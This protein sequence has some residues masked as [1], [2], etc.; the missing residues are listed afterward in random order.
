MMVSD[1]FGPA[2]ETFGRTMYAVLTNSSIAAT[3]LDKLLV[4]QSRTRSTSS[5]V[6]DS[7]A[8]AT[9]FSCAQK[10]YNGAIAVTADEKPCATVLEAA[11]ALGYKTGLVVTSRITHATPASF[12]AHVLWRDYE[13][14]IAE[15][16][17][18]GVAGLPTTDLMLGGGRR[19]FL[20]Q[21]H[22][23][24]VRDDDRDLL[25]E[26][27]ARGFSLGVFTPDHMAFDLDRNPAKEPSLA[28]MAQRALEVLD[29]AVEEDDDVPGFF[30]MVEGSRID[31]AAHSNDPGAHAH[32]IAMYYRT[33]EVVKQWVDAHWESTVMVSTSDHE[34]GGLSLARQVSAK[35]PEYKWTPS[36]VARQRKSAHYVGKQLL[37]LEKRSPK[38]VTSLIADLFGIIDL[39]PAELAY[40]TSPVRTLSELEYFLG[41][42]VVST[43]AELG[44]ATHGHSAVDVNLYAHGQGVDALRGNVEN[45]DV[46]K[47]LHEYLGV[48]EVMQE[49][50]QVMRANVTFKHPTMP[51]P[52]G[53]PGLVVAGMG[54]VE[55][56]EV[57]WA[58]MA[59][60]F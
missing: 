60:H 1:G 34:T 41:D 36:T 14:D 46:G 40:L 28:E 57:E 22:K 33:V 29:Q 11:A 54:R 49:L 16:Q 35:Y 5:L 37:A 24:S 6:T 48:G 53:E 27:R 13:N 32:D 9:A 15:Q 45:T 39:T 23:E 47:F 44:W 43:R 17:V 50:T 52:K 55:S 42:T 18:H 30:L 21:T 4:G 26:A 10:S 3:P 51:P 8:G 38:H 20:P 7:A 2:S 56:D 12:N 59:G 58:R 19:H 31:M 25:A